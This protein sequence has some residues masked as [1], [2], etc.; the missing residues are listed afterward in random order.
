[1]WLYLQ[2]WVPV[3]IVALTAAICF[4]VMSHQKP[5]P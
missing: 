5:H 1:M 3:L 4:I 2:T